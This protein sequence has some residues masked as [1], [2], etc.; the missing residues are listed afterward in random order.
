M[1]LVFSELRPAAKAGLIVGV[2]AALAA[3]WVF[4]ASAIFVV[5]TGL[6]KLQHRLPFLEVYAYWHAYPNDPR[7][8]KWASIGAAGASLIVVAIGAAFLLRRTNESLHGETGFA[9][10]GELQT[11]FRG[12]KES[13]LCGQ[14]RGYLRYAGEQHVGLYAPTGSG[15][16]VSIVNPNALLWDGS[17]V[18]FDPK[19]D[20][21]RLTAGIRAFCHQEVHLF[22]PL[23]QEGRTTRYNPFTYVKRGTSA[24]FDDIQ[25]IGQVLFPS[26]A[27][28]EDFWRASA[29]SAFNGVGALLSESPDLPFTVGEVYR[30][31]TRGDGP[32]YLKRTIENAKQ[33]NRP[34]SQAVISALSDYLAGSENLVNSVR[35]SVTARLE[36]WNNPLIDQATAESDFDLRDLRKRLMA[37]YV[38]V[39]PDNVERLRPLLTLFF[40]QLLDITAQQGEPRFNPLLRRKLLILLDEFPILGRMEKVAEAFA[41]VRSYGV[42]FLM[43][44]QSKAQLRAAYGPELARTIMENCGVEIVFGTD[45]LELSREISERLGYNT[46]SAVSRSRAGSLLSQK[47]TDSKTTSDQRRALMLPQ[48]VRTLSP[49]KCIILSPGM[50]PILADRIIYYADKT[51]TKLLLK[52]PIVKPIARPEPAPAPSPALPVEVASKAAVTQQVAVEAAP[53]AVPEPTDR[54]T[55]APVAAAPATTGAAP[56]RGTEAPPPKKAAG[57]RTRK[58]PAPAAAGAEP[59]EP[60]DAADNRPPEIQ[61]AAEPSRTVDDVP[62]E[63]IPLPAETGPADSPVKPIVTPTRMAIWDAIT[64]AEPNLGRYGLPESQKWIGEIVSQLPG[65]KGEPERSMAM[66]ER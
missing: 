4:L 37:I 14:H 64:A 18:V 5:G 24:A 39:S 59:S 3:G 45:D 21:Y 30:I 60:K 46:V 58:K 10:N 15:K 40:Q 32:L 36:I 12:R 35:R 1:A 44:I 55:R 65:E 43:V 9:G 28:D 47:N 54:G 13:I 53:A 61:P 6:W 56:D 62:P 38:G 42:R 16:G 29:R 2:V 26:V 51:F 48:E 19:K 49:R 22:D 34:Y 66:G 20:I 41:W 25:R 50:R 7:V 33:D 63:W 52:A 31:L 23:D 27:G 17:M 57:S 8:I 11:R